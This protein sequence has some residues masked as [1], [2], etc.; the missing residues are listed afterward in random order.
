MT[1]QNP[2]DPLNNQDLLTQMVQFST[3]QQN[4]GMQNAMTS[5]QSSQELAQANSLLGREVTLQAD[6]ETIT[7]GMVSA[8]S[9]DT[10]TPQIIVNGTAYNLDQVLM[11]TSPP[12]ATP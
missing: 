11:I 8:V 4:S 12:T 7:Q 5:L 6:N 1:A 9:M 2:L 3:L 10:G